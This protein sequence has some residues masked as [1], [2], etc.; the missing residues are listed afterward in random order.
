MSQEQMPAGS[1][2]VAPTTETATPNVS[3]VLAKANKVL[4]KVRVVHGSN[5]QYFELSGKQVGSVRKSLKE[6]FN[7][8]SD[9]KA[10][11]NGE[12]VTDS[13]VLEA[14]VSLEFSKTAGVKGIKHDWIAC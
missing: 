2:A 8:P 6:V 1:R 13:F 7:I 3:A 9:A 12:E 5:E 10:Y 4:S 11:V 14:G